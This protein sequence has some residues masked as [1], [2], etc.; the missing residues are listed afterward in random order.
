[1]ASAFCGCQTVTTDL[2]ILQEPVC[3]I[4]HFPGSGVWVWASL[5]FCSVSPRGN[6]ASWG[7]DLLRG[8]SPLL[9][10]VS[11]G[12]FS[13][14]RLED[15]SPHFLDGCQLETILDTQ[16]TALFPAGGLSTSRQSAASRR[17]DSVWCLFES[18]LF[19][20]L[21]CLFLMSRLYSKGAHQ[22]RLSRSRGETGVQAG[23]QGGWN[24]G[25]LFTTKITVSF[26]LK[27]PECSGA[28]LFHEW[29]APELCIRYLAHFVLSM[30]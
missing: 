4:S 25:T 12:R 8:S 11:V 27:I 17:Q 19:E 10:L 23:A 26:C 6:H 30:V 2:A 18:L 16:R 20:H 28:S 14:L 21:R 29:R 5:V 9:D 13:P 7:G 1:M 3:I 24:L 15:W 22:I